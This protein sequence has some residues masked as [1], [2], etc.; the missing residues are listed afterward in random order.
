[1]TDTFGQRKALFFSR[2]E[3]KDSDEIKNS[4]F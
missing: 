1:M 3:R 2:G 4:H